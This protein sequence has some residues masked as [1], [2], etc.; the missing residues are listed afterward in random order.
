MKPF[1]DAHFGLLRT[2]VNTESWLSD[3]FLST[4]SFTDMSLYVCCSVLIK[5]Q[6]PP[7]YEL[8]QLS[9]HQDMVEHHGNKL[10]KY[11]PH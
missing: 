9:L 2:N 6:I 4:E 5:L 11:S 1:F 10:D 3:Y 8:P 7:L